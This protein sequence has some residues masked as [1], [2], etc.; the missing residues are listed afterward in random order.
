MNLTQHV[1]NEINK[2]KMH[3]PLSGITSYH[4]LSGALTLANSTITAG[5]A[6]TLFTGNGTTQSVV[7]DVDMTTQWGNLASEKFGGLVWGKSRSA[8][9]N[10]FFIDTVRGVTKEINSNTTEAEATLVNS[11]TAFNNNGF[12]L[13]S[14]VGLNTNLATYASWNFQTT[15]QITGTTNHGKAYTCHYNPFTGFT[16]VKYEGS[17]LARHEIPHHLARKLG[18]VTTKALGLVNNWGASYGDDIYLYLNTTAAQATNSTLFDMFDSTSTILGTDG[19]VNASANQYIM[20]GWANSYFDE[21]NTLI[22]NYEVGI[23]QGTGASGNKVTTRGKPALVMIKRV[24]S[25]GNWVILDNQRNDKLLYSNLS[26]AEGSLDYI[27]VLSDGFTIKSTDTD[28]NASGGQYLYMVVY[29]NDA[30]SGKSKY[31]RATDTS[32]LNLNATVPFANGLDVNG[33]KNTILAKN[34]TVSG[35]TLTQGK[36]YLWCDNTGAYGVD[37]H[38]PRYTEYLTRSYAGETPKVY[39]PNENLWYNTTG[40]SE[41]VTNGRFDANITGWTAGASGTIVW[42]AGMLKI[43][44]TTNGTTYGAYQDIA[45]VIGKKYTI[46][47]KFSSTANPNTYVLIDGIIVKSWLSVTSGVFSYT[48]VANSTTT[49]IGVSGGTG[50]AGLVQYYDDISVF[51]PDI[52]LSTPIT[53]SRNYLDAIVYADAN[54]QPTYVEQLPKTEYKDII[55]ANEYQGKNACTAWVNFDG[56]TTPPTIRD[57]FNVKA[58]IRTATGVFDV[59]FEKPMDNT[60]YSVGGASDSTASTGQVSLGN[61]ASI[62]NKQKD[63]VKVNSIVVAT[64]TLTNFSN[65]DVQILG[66]RN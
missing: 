53:N 64:G 13:G 63:K 22:G 56:T 60:N 8:A 31:Y 55:K 38:A 21:A 23:Y 27:D 25:T 4:L 5:M 34:E 61:N 57:S 50:T 2:N 6:T 24:D 19:A 43:T 18:F 42:E 66:G 36:N 39:K 1:A 37:A 15:H 41:L 51:E 59:Y 45:T 54:G 12:S 65:I 14:D 33:A 44:S 32:N 62:A 35:L 20:Y 58:I 9:L 52:T 48:F 17:G 3:I 40:S 10:N 11:L 29:D 46:S 28:V 49:R 7:T 30:G 16:I 47:F 26:N